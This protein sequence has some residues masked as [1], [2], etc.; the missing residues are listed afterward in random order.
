[1]NSQARM[2][3]N[4]RDVSKENAFVRKCE[5]EPVRSTFAPLDRI[6][7]LQ[8]TIG[9]QAAQRLL[10]SGAIRARSGIGSCKHY[11]GVEQQIIC[12]KA[13]PACA[14]SIS[15][16][17]IVTEKTKDAP[18]SYYGASFNHKFATEPEGCSLTG[19]QVTEY[20]ETIR[21]DFNSGQKTVNIGK[22]VWTLTKENK[23][24][25]PDNIWS[26]A[27]AKGLGVNPVNNWPAVMDH[28][29]IWHFRR[30]DKDAWQRGP[31]IVIKVTLHGDRNR[32][33]SLK[34]TTTDHGV[35]REEPYRGPNI[36]MRD[37]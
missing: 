5:S 4:K 31:G 22:N 23:L 29:Q 24:H 11:A 26:P 33:D 3:D 21:D 7:Y 12:R 14:L 37:Q 16:H 32:K 8:R 2:S 20:V 10:L 25:K 18:P 1:M 34:V 6:L 17:D 19:V 9:N 36:R 28:N 13:D 30:S 35:S 27:G 15:T